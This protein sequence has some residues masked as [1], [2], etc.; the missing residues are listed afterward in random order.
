MDEVA[1]GGL[2]THIPDRPWGRLGEGSLQLSRDFFL[3]LSLEGGL[4]HTSF[5]GGQHR[6][7]Y[8][9]VAMVQCLP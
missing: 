7:I 9:P 5:G 2:R 1:T 8:F 6:N 3:S 4:G